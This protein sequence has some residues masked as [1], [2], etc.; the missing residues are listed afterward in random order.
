M[1]ET[2]NGLWDADVLFNKWGRRVRGTINNS[3]TV[4][5]KVVLIQDE[6]IARLR[7]KD[8]RNGVVEYCVRS[9]KSTDGRVSIRELA[10]RTGYSRRYLDLL[11]R[12]HVGLSPKV[13]A[14][15]FRFQRFY[16]RWAEGPIG[17][18]AD[19]RKCGCKEIT[20]PTGPAGRATTPAANSVARPAYSLTAPPSIT[21]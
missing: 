4:D 16:R 6:L 7:E 1:V 18:K 15:I 3:Q 19:P 14:G 10:Q 17:M 20:A 2:F 9:P 13:L 21:S 8:R 11:F 5:Q 12:R